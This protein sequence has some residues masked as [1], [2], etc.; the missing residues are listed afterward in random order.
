MIL[1]AWE[2][3]LTFYSETKS[4]RDEWF[5]VLQNTR[6]NAKEYKLSITKNLRN[7]VKYIIY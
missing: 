2:R 4:E 6:K 7:I 1:D 5:E 3:N